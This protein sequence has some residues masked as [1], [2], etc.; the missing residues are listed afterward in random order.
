[1]NKSII[2]L[3]N[4]LRLSDNLAIDHVAKNNH[5]ILFLYIQDK[6]LGSAS[7]WFLHQSLDAF[8][9]DIYQKYQAKLIIK[10]GN[11]QDILEN[12]VK[13]YQIN[14]IFWNRIYEPKKIQRDIKIKKYFKN[15]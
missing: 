13:K 4:D 10:S 1:M 12:L 3:R 15:S 2:W 8:K 11:E 14:S 6:S 5:Q 7:K 9:K